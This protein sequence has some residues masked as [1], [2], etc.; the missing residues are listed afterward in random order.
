MQH[1]PREKQQRETST[2]LMGKQSYVWKMQYKAKTGGTKCMRCM[3]THASSRC[4]LLYCR[5]CNAYGHSAV[6]C[7]LLKEDSA[8]AQGFGTS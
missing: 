2:V 7:A 1:E 6:V 4:P 5:K 8:Q 3:Y